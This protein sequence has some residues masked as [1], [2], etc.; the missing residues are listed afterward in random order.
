MTGLPRQSLDPPEP[1]LWTGRVHFNGWVDITDED[2]CLSEEDAI[3]AAREIIGVTDCECEA[4]FTEW[5]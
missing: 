1:K 2:E 3:A 4:E 5:V